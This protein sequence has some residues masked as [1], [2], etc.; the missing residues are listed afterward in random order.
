MHL[1]NVG[2]ITFNEINI[3][4]NILSS[5]SEVHIMSMR[6]LSRI[7]LLSA[8]LVCF[9]T[10]TG[11]GQSINVK[12]L[13]KIQLK[14]YLA[15]GLEWKGETTQN[16]NWNKITETPDGKIWYCGGDHWG[17]DARKADRYDRP[18]GFGNTAISSYDAKT[19]R[20]TVRFELDRASAIFSNAETPGHGKI[21]SNIQH[22]SEGNLY[23]AGYL[24]SSYGHEYTQAYY[25]KSYTGGAVIK[26]NPAN[27]DVD[28]FGIPC[29]GSAVVGLYFDEKHNIVNGITV[30][31]AKF[32]RINLNTMEVNIYESVARM[33]RLV[34]RVREFVMDYDGFCYFA[35]DLGGLTRFNPDTEVFDDI[36][37]V[38]PGEKMDFRASVV[39]KKNVLYGISTDGFVWSYDSKTGKLDNYGHVLELPDKPHYTPNIALDEQWGRLY[40]IAGN[41]G[42]QVYEDALEILTILDLKSRKFY[43]I[44]IVDDIEG[45]FGALCASDHTVYFSCFG[46]NRTG[47][48]TFEIGSNG[49]P[50]TRP[51]LIKYEPPK[52]LSELR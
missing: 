51:C 1:G 29:P 34:D 38:L 37:I 11:R 13:K 42:G 52:T 44:G 25:P 4:V 26:Y 9:I 32:W 10:A 35:N 22:D 2:Y 15:G 7:V 45:C 49:R 21:H 30:N 8:L 6:M 36:D 48:D 3:A 17:T 39:S 46:K 16:T 40:F 33:T 27:G 20:A 47:K 31:R 28:Y 41:H 14:S 5:L 24:G 12:N 18:W 50:I 43:W 23:M 19:D